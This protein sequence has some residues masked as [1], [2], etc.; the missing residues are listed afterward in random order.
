MIV[1]FNVFLIP[2]NIHFSDV[3]GILFAVIAGNAILGKRST[4]QPFNVV[5]GGG[6]DD[7]GAPVPTP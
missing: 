7:N 2:G 3:Y 4:G 1:D 6:G 5:H